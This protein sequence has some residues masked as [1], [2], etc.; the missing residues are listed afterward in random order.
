[1]DLLNAEIKILRNP[2]KDSTISVVDKTGQE[3]VLLTCPEHWGVMQVCDAARYAE[4]S[5]NLLKLT[6]QT[7]T[8]PVQANKEPFKR[9]DLVQLIK[10]DKEPKL[11]E[12]VFKIREIGRI[13][14][15]GVLMPSYRISGYFNGRTIT[16]RRISNELKFYVKGEEGK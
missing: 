15:S 2:I 7:Q 10:S 4:I 1:M 16:L 13:E 12:V 9:G 5:L 14:Y 11:L 8:P 6:I 3:E